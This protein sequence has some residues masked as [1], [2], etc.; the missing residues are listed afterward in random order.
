MFRAGSVPRCIR[1]YEARDTAEAGSTSA[2]SAGA[3]VGP[4]TGPLDGAILGGIFSAEERERGVV[5]RLRWHES[6]PRGSRAGRSA[7]PSGSADRT[8]HRIQVTK[9]V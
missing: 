1:A 4:T 6:T 3:P 2:L 7:P 9:Y 5:P 8:D